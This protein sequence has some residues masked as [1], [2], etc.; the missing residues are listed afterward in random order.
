[1]YTYCICSCICIVVHVAGSGH[2]AGEAAAVAVSEL[3]RQGPEDGRGPEAGD[4]EH[5]DLLLGKLV[6]LVQ[7]VDIRP[8]R[9]RPCSSAASSSR[10]L[11]A[12][13]HGRVRV[14]MRHDASMGV[15]D[16]LEPVGRHGAEVGREVHPASGLR[17][18]L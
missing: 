7:R 16:D 6:V 3:A 11:P 12:L 10:V 14:R 1:M 13:A 4:E 18:A 2:Q 15:D 5:P 9:A 17:S 8:L